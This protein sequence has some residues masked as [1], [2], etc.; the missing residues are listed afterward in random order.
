[1]GQ[2]INPTGFRL[3]VTKNWA[4]RW[5]A[6]GPEF[7]RMLSEDLKVNEDRR[8]GAIVWRNLLFGW[9]WKRAGVPEGQSFAGDLATAMRRNGD[10][11][12]LV[13]SGYY[14]MVTTPAAAKDALTKA[15]VPEDRVTVRNY[16][17]GHML[18]LGDTAAAFSDDVRAL[19][20]GGRR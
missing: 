19:I 20:R 11:R 10:L 18:Y 12:V 17:S 6:T 14:D 3:P 9:N 13:A 7:P 1:M 16:E 15:G 5:F 2:K 4:S 8:Y